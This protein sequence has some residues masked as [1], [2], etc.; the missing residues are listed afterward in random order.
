M[1]DLGYWVY[2]PAY[3]NITTYGM[4]GAKSWSG[5]FYGSLGWDGFL[6]DNRLRGIVGF[7]GLK[8]NK[9]YIGFALKVGL[10]REHP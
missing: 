3:G 2:Y 5:S 10:Q 4:S 9:N 1:V 7:S 8:I 6:F